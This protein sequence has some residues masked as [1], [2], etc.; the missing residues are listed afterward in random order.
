[1][2]ESQRELVVAR[3]LEHADA[4]EDV[5][6]IAEPARLEVD[7]GHRHIGG[8][9]RVEHLHLVRHVFEVDDFGDGRVEALQR[10]A[11]VFRIEGPGQHV[12]ARE[13]VEQGAR[14]CG[15]AD[16]ALVGANQ[17][18]SGLHDL[19]SKLTAESLAV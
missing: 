17:D 3:G 5:E 2:E 4:L 13:E 19:T 11:R 16:A 10:A 15:L 7:E 18:E 1:M 12:L 9:H 6:G 14:D 8:F